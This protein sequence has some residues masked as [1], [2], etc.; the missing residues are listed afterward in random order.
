MTQLHSSAATLQIT[1]DT[2]DP[3]EITQLLDCAPTDSCRKG[4]VL[5]TPSGKE[6]IARFGRW[7]LE[8]RDSEPGDLNSQVVEIFDKLRS[9][10]SAWDMVRKRFA[11]I[12][13]CGLFTREW[14]EAIT[15]SPNT[16]AC[17][18][19]RGIELMLELYTGPMPTD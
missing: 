9:D 17:L 16:L 19:S 2:L 7:S 5:R 18:G 3:D 12:L 11:L 4:D 14:N 15:I 10:P 6:L 1:G 13:Y 8:A